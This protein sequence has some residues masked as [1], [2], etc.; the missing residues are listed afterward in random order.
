M[1][2]NS[3]PGHSPLPGHDYER[4]VPK[5]NASANVYT[6]G[7]I[8]IDYCKRPLNEVYAEIDTY[9]GWSGT[10]D[11]EDESRKL[12]LGGILLD[13]TP[14]HHSTLRAEYLES[15]RKHVK[16]SEGILRNRLVSQ[17]EGNP[18]KA[19]SPCS[20]LHRTSHSAL[21]PLLLLCTGGYFLSLGF[22]L[23]VWLIIALSILFCPPMSPRSE[24]RGSL[25]SHCSCHQWGLWSS[26]FT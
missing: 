9:A 8:R 7:Y 1:N 11:S 19:T 17:T 10:R 16:A 25:Q 20:G 14:N 15:I 24:L 12:G 26:I 21:I 23:F 6:V 18:K 13:E 5:L 4:E 2:P 3:G 22:P